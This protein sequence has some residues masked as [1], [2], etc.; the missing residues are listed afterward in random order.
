MTRAGGLVAR[1][2]AAA[3]LLALAL[4]ACSSPSGPVAVPSEDLP[5][6]L[7]R[8]VEASESGGPQ[9]EFLA[10]FVRRGRLVAV[11]RALRTPL[12]LPEAAMRALLE[13]P[14]PRERDRAI[15]SEIPPKTRLIRVI[16]VNRVAQVDLSGEF[17]GPAT[18]ESI[19]LRVAQVVWTLARLPD[20]ETVRF[21][22]D[23]APVNAVTERGAA[24]DRPVGTGDYTGVAPRR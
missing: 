11:R 19:L 1:R 14:T 4:T 18:S 3:V 12:P 15:A 8:R 16:V 10:Y 23:G 22:I 7:R 13:G 21:T 2:S 20:L 9:R 24:V 17:Q 6:E 5:F